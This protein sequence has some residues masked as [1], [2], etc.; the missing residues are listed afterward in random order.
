VNS[1]F[2]QSGHEPALAFSARLY[3]A[4]VFIRQIN[5]F[6]EFD[7]AIAETDAGDLVRCFVRGADKLLR[8]ISKLPTSLQQS[9]VEVAIYPPS[10]S[11]VKWLKRFAPNYRSA[12]STDEVV[13]K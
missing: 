8:A 2:R 1:V 10:K 9:D 3:L 7:V 11:D 4:Q 5:R 13:R 12:G 6:A